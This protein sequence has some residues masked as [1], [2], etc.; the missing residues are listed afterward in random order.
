M[1]V[2]TAVQQ[3][4]FASFIAYDMTRSIYCRCSISVEILH[5]PLVPIFRKKLWDHQVLYIFSDIGH[6]LRN[7]WWKTITIPDCLYAIS[8]QLNSKLNRNFSDIIFLDYLIFLWNLWILQ[9]TFSIARIETERCKILQ[10]NIGCRRSMVSRREDLF[11]PRML[12]RNAIADHFPEQ[13]A[14]RKQLP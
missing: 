1:F 8:G 9:K 3:L 13:Q 6:L 10:L 2:S 14:I 7:L 5:W 12:T 4:W 11:S